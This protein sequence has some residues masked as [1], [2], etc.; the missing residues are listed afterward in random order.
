MRG[1]DHSI[2]SSLRY[3]WSMKVRAAVKKVCK[4]CRTVRRRG[5]LYVTCKANPKHK[6][7]QGLHSSAAQSLFAAD[8]ALSS[9]GAPGSAVQRLCG[10]WPGVRPEGHNPGDHPAVRRHAELPLEPE[11]G[12]G[13]RQAV[14][15][16]AHPPLVGRVVAPRRHRRVGSDGDPGKAEGARTTGGRPRDGG[17]EA[18]KT[19]EQVV[20]EIG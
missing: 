15:A 9:T 4:S 12:E 7:R 5:V 3:S 13:L 14:R 16:R 17:H 19:Q 1:R 11:G 6:Q 18:R 20:V 10:L 2:L 8:A